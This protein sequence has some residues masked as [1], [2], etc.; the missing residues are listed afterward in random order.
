[1]NALK[2]KV[3]GMRNPDNIRE[4]AA[5]APDYM[6]FIFYEGSPRYVGKSFF[7]PE[8]LP[9]TVKRVGVFVNESTQ[10]ILSLASLNRLQ[11]VQLHGNEPVD[12][13]DAIRSAGLEV[14]KAFAVDDHFTFSDLKPYESSVDY[15]LF[16][17]R[18]KFYGGNG[19]P[20]NWSILQ[21][22]DQQVPF[23]LSGGLS[24]KN[25]EEVFR[26]TTM[27]LYA[28][29]INS[30]VEVSPGMKDVHQVDQLIHR[31][32]KGFSTNL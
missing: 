20:F 13:C 14:I 31:T 1:M 22:Y 2:V 29:D 26:L 21:R 6:G 18:G 17:T 9:A 12:Q 7:I 11:A 5:L 16:D 4:I 8:E 10:T 27:N 32:R 28:L 23:F 30:G 15:F 24:T 19:L 3:C 25:L